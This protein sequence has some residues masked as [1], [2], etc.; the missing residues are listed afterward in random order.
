MLRDMGERVELA[1][2]GIVGIRADNPGPFSLTGT[3]SWLLGDRP[4]WL[5]DPG[6][7][8]APHVDALAGEI[9]ARG[10]ALG[11]IALTHD[12]ADHNE[13]VPA[14]RERFPDAPVAAARG[15]ADVLLADGDRFGPLEAMALPGH[16]P[17]HLVFLHADVAFSGDAVLGTG[18]VFVAP[19]PGALAG[20]L[21]GLERLRTRGPAVICPGHGP[22]VLDAP[23]KLTEYIEHRL[24]RERRLL[25]ALDAGRR[26]VDDLLDEAWSDAPAL[27]RPAAAVTLRAHLDKLAG[28][29]RLPDGVEMPPWDPAWARHA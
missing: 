13:A 2:R 23:A 27:L 3:N 6:P 5:I 28:E 16:A 22:V 7:A 9:A 8:L 18:S 17:D 4:T 15:E 26:S 24:E 25:A 14:I 11:G 1:G 21:A 29:G 20:Y 10:G 19:D 12:H